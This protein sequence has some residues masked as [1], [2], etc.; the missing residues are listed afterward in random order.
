LFEMSGARH[1]QR[2]KF[3]LIS[4]DRERPSS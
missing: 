3:A 4:N 2:Q 1:H